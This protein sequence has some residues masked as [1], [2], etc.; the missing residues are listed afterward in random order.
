MNVFNSFNFHQNL[1]LTQV[2]TLHKTQN[3]RQQTQGK[4]T[5]RPLPIYKNT[6]PNILQNQCA[7][8]KLWCKN[9]G[10]KQVLY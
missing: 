5:M 7:T 8:I 3:R 4:V 2:M 9:V 6:G 1:K 10:I